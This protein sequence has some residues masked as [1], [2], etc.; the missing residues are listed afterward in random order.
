MAKNRN[1]NVVGSSIYANKVSAGDIVH[2]VLEP[3]N[4][5]DKNAI[6]IVNSDGKTIGYVPKASAIEFQNFRTGKYPFY[7][8]KVKEVWKGRLADVPQVLAHFTKNEEELPYQS[9]K[10]LS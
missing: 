2:F 5:T 7:C 9:Q 3:D 1:F 10:W 4:S 8:A 6:R